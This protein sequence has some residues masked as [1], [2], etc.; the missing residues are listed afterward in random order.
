MQYT[1]TTLRHKIRVKI[2]KVWILNNLI[3][4]CVPIKPHL[5]KKGQPNLYCLIA[6]TVLQLHLLN[7]AHQCL[8]YSASIALFQF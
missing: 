3:Y 4:K 1:V 7:K 6:D 8:P 5:L 2:L